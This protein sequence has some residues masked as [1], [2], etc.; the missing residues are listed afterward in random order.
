[1]LKFPEKMVSPVVVLCILL[2]GC[3]ATDSAPSV[4]TVLQQLQAN[5]LLSNFSQLVNAA[6]DIA[7]K[8]NDPTS[9]VTLFAP[10]NNAFAAL[11]SEQ[12]NKLYANKSNACLHHALFGDILTTALKPTQVLE[13][14]AGDSL[15]IKRDLSTSKVHIA[16]ALVTT[17]DIIAS[18]GVMDIINKVLLQGGPTPAPGTPTPGPASPTPG[19]PTPPAPAP[20]TPGSPTPPA[21]APPTPGSPTPVPAPPGACTGSSSGLNAVTC[22]AWQDLAKATNIAGWTKCSGTLLDP[23]SCLRHVFCANG[24]ITIL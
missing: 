15:V 19:S 1:L 4:K 24:D 2:S 18:N 22:A 14:L 17:T 20:P 23:C 6:G 12:L 21:P 9:L 5:P 8:L 10:T 7:A 11:T 13:T 3:S 16:D